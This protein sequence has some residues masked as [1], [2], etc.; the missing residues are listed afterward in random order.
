M[1]A[2]HHKI[3]AFLRDTYPARYTASQLARDM[4]EN[5]DDTRLALLELAVG[6]GINGHEQHGKI[7]Y[8]AKELT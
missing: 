8:Y 3:V 1:T 4:D 7:I 5:L 6:H 2:L